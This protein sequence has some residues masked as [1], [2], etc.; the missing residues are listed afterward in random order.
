MNVFGDLKIE[1]KE[2]KTTKLSFKSP[3]ELF[4]NI[5]HNYNYSFLLES[6]ESDSGLARFSVL[7]FEPVAKLKA[8]GNILEIEKNGEKE[9]IYV[10]NP[11]MR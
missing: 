6:M 2:P 3:F 8:Y 4:K 10:E 11:L 9:E 7:G 1:I 5:Y